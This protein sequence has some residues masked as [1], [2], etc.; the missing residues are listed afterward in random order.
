MIR[1][2]ENS[3]NK[4]FSTALGRVSAQVLSQQIDEVFDSGRNLRVLGC[5]YTTPYLSGVTPMC[6]RLIEIRTEETNS[7]ATTDRTTPKGLGSGLLALVESGAIPFSQNAFDRIVA[8]HFLELSQHLNADL[9]ELHRIVQPEGQLVLVV[10]NRMGL[11]SRSEQT[12]FAKG[13]PFTPTQ[14]R[15]VLEQVGFKVESCKSALYFAPRNWHLNLKVSRFVENTMRW[16]GTWVGR[17]PVGG[18][19]IVSVRKRQIAP[20]KPRGLAMRLAKFWETSAKPAP[21]SLEQD[22]LPVKKAHEKT[23]AGL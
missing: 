12:P 2:H 1:H 11:W 3:R 13:Q 19:L 10:P 18:V 14:I 21:V 16:L 22:P 20:P 7:L 15:H 5:G 4:Y 6:E 8:T 17:P 23:D 9:Y